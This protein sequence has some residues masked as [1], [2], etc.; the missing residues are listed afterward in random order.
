MISKEIKGA[1]K[2]NDDVYND[3]GVGESRK[4]DAQPSQIYASISAEHKAKK[5]LVAETT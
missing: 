3:V 1:V 2:S 5:R 4:E